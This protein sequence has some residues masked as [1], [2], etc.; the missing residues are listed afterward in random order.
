MSE[1]EVSLEQYFYSQSKEALDKLHKKLAAEGYQVS[2]QF[3]LGTRVKRSG[4]SLQQKK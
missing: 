2:E 4:L 1:D 3:L